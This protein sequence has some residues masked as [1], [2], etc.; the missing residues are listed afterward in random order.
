MKTKDETNFL[1]LIKYIFNIYNW[2]LNI[3]CDT[4]NFSRGTKH[5]LATPITL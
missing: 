1:N 4:L 2:H 5:P 3:L